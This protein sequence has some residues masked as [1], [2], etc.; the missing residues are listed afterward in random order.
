MKTFLRNLRG[1]RFGAGFPAKE[2]RDSRKRD[3]AFHFEF[4][5]IG[6][7]SDSLGI[8]GTMPSLVA[9]APVK[10]P[11]VDLVLELIF[12]DSPRSVGR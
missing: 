7:G 12:E 5:W 6:A 2:C 1:R 9:V 4:S 10:F 3:N 11:S 8:R